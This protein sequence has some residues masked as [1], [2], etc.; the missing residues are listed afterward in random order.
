MTHAARYGSPVF[1][2]EVFIN[3]RGNE[4]SL[5]VDLKEQMPPGGEADPEIVKSIDLALRQIVK[6]LNSR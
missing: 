1:H 3:K 5:T 4:Y 6:K 2:A